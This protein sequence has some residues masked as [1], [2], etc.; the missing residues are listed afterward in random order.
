MDNW[1]AGLQSVIMSCLHGLLNVSLP[2]SLA[3]LR[4]SLSPIGYKTVNTSFL[5]AQIVAHQDLELS[6]ISQIHLHQGMA[7]Y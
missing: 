3:S 1:V 5:G 7:Q 2:S 6:V 4:A